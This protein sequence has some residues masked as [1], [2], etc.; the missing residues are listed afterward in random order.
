MREF[1]TSGSVGAGGGKP[2]SATRRRRCWRSGAD[3]QRVRPGPSVCTCQR[4][5]EAEHGARSASKEGVS[6]DAPR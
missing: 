1:R 4:A 2:P 6:I 5:I 3:G